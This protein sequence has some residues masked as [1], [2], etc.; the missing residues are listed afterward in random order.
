[1][2]SFEFQDRLKHIV[3]LHYRL[4]NRFL[5]TQ[6]ITYETMKGDLNIEPKTIINETSRNSAAKLR[7]TQPTAG[8]IVTSLYI[9]QV[10][11]YLFLEET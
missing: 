10:S 5:K 9:T 11:L 7:T 1:M 3:F 6:L 8:Q 2:R 4:G